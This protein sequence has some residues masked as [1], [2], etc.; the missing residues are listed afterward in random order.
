M[1][2]AALQHRLRRE[3]PQARSRK[4]DCEWDAVQ[5]TANLGYDLGV[6]ITGLS[7]AYLLHATDMTE[8]M[9]SVPWMVL[10]AAVGFL[11]WNLAVP[12]L[13][14]AAGSTATVGLCTRAKYIAFGPGL[15]GGALVALLAHGLLVTT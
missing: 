11:D 7:H 8:P 14:L 13:A 2:P 9:A 12:A 4:F 5:A 6:A 3:H 1:W 10:G 15:V